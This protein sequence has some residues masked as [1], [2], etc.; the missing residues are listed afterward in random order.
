MTDLKVCQFE[1]DLVEGY[2][3]D[4]SKVSWQRNSVIYVSPKSIYISPLIVFLN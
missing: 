4:G 1:D 3:S 2:F